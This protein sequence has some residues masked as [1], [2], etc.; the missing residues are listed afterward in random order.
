M[1][2][3]YSRVFQLKHQPPRDLPDIPE[4]FSSDMLVV[5][6]DLFRIAALKINPDTLKLDANIAITLYYNIFALA[7]GYDTIELYFQLDGQKQHIKDISLYEKMS[8]EEQK[9]I[10]YIAGTLKH[11]D[12]SDKLI[13]NEATSNYTARVRDR[14]AYSRLFS[15]ND[16]PDENTTQAINEKFPQ[17]HVFNNT[18]FMYKNSHFEAISNTNAD[19][20]TL[21]IP[22]TNQ[23]KEMTAVINHPDLT[24][25]TDTSRFK[26]ACHELLDRKID[27]LQTFIKSNFIKSPNARSPITNL[28]NE[29]KKLVGMFMSLMSKPPASLVSDAGVGT[30][31]V[32][33]V[34]LVNSFTNLKKIRTRFLLQSFSHESLQN[35]CIRL[36]KG[37]DRSSTLE[38][39][40]LHD[41][42]HAQRAYC[43]ISRARNL[44]AFP[45]N[46]PKR[47]NGISVDIAIERNQSINDEISI[48][49]A[50]RVASRDARLNGGFSC[51]PLKRGSSKLISSVPL[52]VIGDNLLKRDIVLNSRTGE[53]MVNSTVLPSKILGHYNNTR[54]EQLLSNVRL[55]ATTITLD[56]GS[57]S[58]LPKNVI[59]IIGKPPALSIFKVVCEPMGTGAPFRIPVT[60]PSTIEIQHL[61]PIAGGRY[62]YKLYFRDDMGTVSLVSVDIL[63]RTLPRGP[64]DLRLSSPQRNQRYM[65]INISQQSALNV[66]EN[67]KSALGKIFSSVPGAADYYDE[68]FKE[69]VNKNLQNIGQ[70][71]QLYVTYYN[72]KTGSERSITLNSDKDEEEINYFNI[73]IGGANADHIITYH[74]AIT[75]PLELVTAGFEEIEDP[76]TRE[77]FQRRTAA[78]FN[79][80]TLT[81]GELPAE[82][83]EKQTGAK[84]YA[85]NSRLNPLDPFNRVS[86][87]GG[88]IEEDQS[89]D[90]VYHNVKE[91]GSVY[92]PDDGECIV[93]WRCERIRESLE[94][95]DFFV[96]TAEVADV[97]FP[98]TGH[99]FIGFTSYKIRTIPFL[100]AASNV[101]FRVYTVYN[102]F[103]VQLSTAQTQVTVVDVRKRIQET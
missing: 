72:K 45:V 75:N 16:S 62:K 69:R 10:D 29:E 74:L 15:S 103:H 53:A 35:L 40:A 101:K 33:D 76:R 61:D 54:I 97:E 41:K 83:T 77:K 36:V 39:I 3:P 57:H 73:Q 84:F 86:C 49:S 85:N 63:H 99:P 80:F 12:E 43:D 2:I 31:A 68:F 59:R 8:A 89:L 28:T 96:V 102:D 6:D 20:P 38:N 27:P 42:I 71:F 100:G 30:S 18:A 93:H 81:R 91:V 34:K 47:K 21:S 1:K 32:S 13:N 11:I 82:Y 56:D 4:F 67:I 98:V 87:I 44:G 19:A 26:D 55:Y 14:N 7:F 52:S 46:F 25:G 65:R 88:M 23:F 50:N 5:K 90:S 66:A 51:Q 95:I 64:I 78:F 17:I 92:N 9:V 70:L 94:H 24:T 22:F 37:K 79:T 48:Y 58:G 60:D